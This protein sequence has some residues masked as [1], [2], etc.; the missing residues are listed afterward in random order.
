V[1][2]VSSRATHPQFAR[3]VDRRHRLQRS[4]QHH[5][6]AIIYAFVPVQTIE[7]ISQRNKP[8]LKPSLWCITRSIKRKFRPSER[9]KQCGSEDKTV[10]R[11]YKRQNAELALPSPAGCK[12]SRAE[13]K[14]I[15]SEHTG[16]CFNVVLALR[17][18]MPFRPFPCRRRP[19]TPRPRPRPSGSAAMAARVAQRI[20][21]LAAVG[22][23]ASTPA[24][25]TRK[26]IEGKRVKG[27]RAK[28]P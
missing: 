26:R 9:R 15:N 25:T 12:S 19:W 16:A 27:A 11:T 3:P 20:C 1:G 14:L 17:P 8:Y 22:D 23:V 4:D 24:S 18:R 28:A 6:P 2:D 13:R 10:A 21:W 7:T 5:S